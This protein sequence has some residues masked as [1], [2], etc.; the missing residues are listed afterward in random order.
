[1]DWSDFQL[2]TATGCGQFLQWAISGSDRNRSDLFR[3]NPGRNPFVRIPV[4]LGSVPIGF[5]WESCEF[6][7]Y[8]T[9]Y[10]MVSC[11]IHGSE[12]I[13]WVGAKNWK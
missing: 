11:R 2:F 9:S 7:C 10:P 12:W 1:L 8:P 4:K 6:R 13:T 5:I 3:C